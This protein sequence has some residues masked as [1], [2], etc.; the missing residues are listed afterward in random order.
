[1]FYMPRNAI[2][3][4]TILVAMNQ[5]GPSESILPK[6]ECASIISDSNRR[7]YRRN[8]RVK[9]TKG[10]SINPMVEAKRTTK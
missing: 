4:L 1:M 10:R 2:L 5:H 3:P 9:T 7:M 8:Q 6:V